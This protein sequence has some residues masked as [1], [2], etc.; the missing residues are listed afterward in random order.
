MLRNYLL[1]VII[2]IFFI[3]AVASS[4]FEFDPPDVGPGF[5][6][7]SLRP[8]GA[9]DGKSKS[10]KEESVKDKKTYKELTS[11]GFLS[12]H[13]CRFYNSILLAK[14]I[15]SPTAEHLYYCKNWNYLF[16]TKNVS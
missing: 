4:S 10:G 7:K 15:P 8:L 13:L 2:V 12:N 3:A 11:L 16:Y 5:A 9:K 6:I 14:N 1:T